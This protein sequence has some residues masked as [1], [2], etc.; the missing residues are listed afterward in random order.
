MMQCVSHLY[1]PLCHNCA[2]YFKGNS[3]K[4]LH[5]PDFLLCLTVLSCDTYCHVTGVFAAV[6]R[7]K[8]MPSLCQ[9]L[10]PLILF[11]S[12]C[13]LFLLYDS[14]IWISLRADTGIFFFSSSL[15]FEW[16]QQT[17][18]RTFHWH[19]LPKTINMLRCFSLTFP[20]MNQTVPLT[21]C[22]YWITF[23]Q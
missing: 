9:P 5:F 1:C 14:D 23:H 21:Y 2:I 20:T 4:R 16:P 11:S 19:Q 6:I 12:S 15:S 13:L 3:L 17:L 8:L 22:S 7:S 10:P 18:T